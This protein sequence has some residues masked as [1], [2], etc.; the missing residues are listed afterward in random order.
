MIYKGNYSKNIPKQERNVICEQFGK[1]LQLPSSIVNL[2]QSEDVNIE[3]FIGLNQST[4]G[5]I[6]TLSGNEI[7]DTFSH[8]ATV[9]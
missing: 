7:I 5:K 1:V 6:K 4:M 9:V 3:Q 8:L 2:L